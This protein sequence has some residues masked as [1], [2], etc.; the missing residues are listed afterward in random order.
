MSKVPVRRTAVA[1]S[2][3]SLS[4]ALTA[5]GSEDEKKDA[6]GDAKG[7]PSAAAAP[8]AKALT[9][10]E[11]EKLA[12]AKAD[13][14]DHEFTDP[15]PGDIL[16]SGSAVADKPACRPLAAAAMEGTPGTAVARVSRMIMPVPKTAPTPSGASTD[17]KIETG[18]KNAA[19]SLDRISM[20]FTTLSTYDG[21]GAADAMAALKKAGTDCAA[22]FGVTVEGDKTKITKVAPAAYGGGD[23][24]I[25][26]TLTMDIDGEPTETQLVTVRKGGTIAN[27][28]TMLLGEKAAPSKAIPDAQVKKLG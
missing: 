3:I 7:S 22:G 10:A 13:L 25:A 20:T 23:E 6:K 19:D 17:E 9:Q 4:L 18:L 27:F 16:K 12:L 14:K 28:F 11:L 8:A 15:E 21:T 5:C 24:A 2:L 1:A 26:H